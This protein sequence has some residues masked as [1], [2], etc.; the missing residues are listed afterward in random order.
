MTLCIQLQPEQVQPPLCFWLHQLEQDHRHSG[1]Q[2]RPA[3]EP[4]AAGRDPVGVDLNG[5][6]EEQCRD[7]VQALK[8]KLDEARKGIKAGKCIVLPKKGEK[9]FK[10]AIPD[11]VRGSRKTES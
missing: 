4:R 7:S 2:S 8:E 3:E 5:W 6:T 10:P 11:S 9:G 1:D